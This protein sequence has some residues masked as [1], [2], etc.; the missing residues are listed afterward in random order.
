MIDANYLLLVRHNSP[1]TTFATTN[2][3]IINKNKNK[4]LSR[5]PGLSLCYRVRN[6]EH[7][8]IP[9]L[10]NV[11]QLTPIFPFEMASIQT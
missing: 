9:I 4:S 5:S 2:I 3:N 1:A 11:T 8:I 7:I 10:P 6:R